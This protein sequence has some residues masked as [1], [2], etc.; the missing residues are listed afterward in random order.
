MK[1]AVPLII[2]VGLCY[3]LFTGIDFHQMVAIIR[4]QCD[5]RWVA[6]G[7]VLAVFFACDPCF[8]MGHTT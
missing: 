5:Y 2:S 6:A 7:L 4:D 1:Y 3:L 8:P